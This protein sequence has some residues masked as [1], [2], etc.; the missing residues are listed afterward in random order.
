MTGFGTEHLTEWGDFFAYNPASRHRR[1]ILTA[2][3]DRLDFKTVL[4]VGCGD[5]SLL[6]EF[7]TRFG[8]QVFGLD[9]DESPATKALH[10]KLDGFYALD[11]SK[12]KP[13]RT[14]DV[15]VC[16]EALEHMPDDAGALANLHAL[17]DRHLLVTVP[18]GPI[19]RTDA[20]MGHVRHYTLESLRA[21]VTA[22][23]FTVVESFA[24]GFPFHSFY[25]AMQDVVPGQIMTGFGN[26]RYGF[27]QKA[28]SH[29][30]YA[31]FFLN[32]RRGG[33]QLFLLAEKRRSP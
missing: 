23:G 30:L 11:V 25:K 27:F 15:I 28:V 1:R 4:D 12:T 29:L 2:W 5:G 9:S 10:A 3:L 21:K 32:A 8:C 18:A 20:H 17:C 22:A 6:M 33:C 31:L 14:F 13:G 7:K 16:A 26:V 24:W 19:R